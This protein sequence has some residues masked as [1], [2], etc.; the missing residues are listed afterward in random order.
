MWKAELQAHNEALIRRQEV[1]AEAW[2]VL[3]AADV[4]EEA[5]EAEWMARRAAALSATEMSVVFN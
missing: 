1:L 3:A 5:F 4:D 2:Q